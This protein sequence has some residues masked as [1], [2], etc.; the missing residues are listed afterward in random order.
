MIITFGKSASHC[1]IMAVRWQWPFLNG[2]HC[3]WTTVLMAVQWQTPSLNDDS[4]TVCS[5]MAVW[6]LSLFYTILYNNSIVCDERQGHFS[7]CSL[8][9]VTV[10][11]SNSIVC[12]ERQGLFSSGSLMIV[13]VL[14]NHS[15]VCDE[16]HGLFFNGRSSYRYCW[17]RRLAV[18]I[19]LWHL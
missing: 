3:F 8:M 18:D 11:Y 10:L 19:D 14:Y 17:W 15:I 5:S 1:W 12:D 9:I 6:W 16:R 13:T 4:K 2:S 7:N